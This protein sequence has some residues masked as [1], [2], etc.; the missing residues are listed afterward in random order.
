MIKYSLF[1]PGIDTR[2][3]VVVEFTSVTCIA[4]SGVKMA[5]VCKFS[6]IPLLKLTS[7]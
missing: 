5:W 4:N 6:I 1:N 7:V 2:R 3:T